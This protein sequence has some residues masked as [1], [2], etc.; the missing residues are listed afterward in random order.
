MLPSVRKFIN[1]SKEEQDI[2]KLFEDFINEVRGQPKILKVGATA[3]E[4]TNAIEDRTYIGIYYN[5]PNDKEVL[6]GFRLI[7]PYCYGKGYV[8]KRGGKKKVVYPNR[9]YIRAFVIR[10]S[11]YDSQFK[12][13]K[14]PF[15]RRKSASKTKK[16]PYWRLFRV[17]RIETWTTMKRKF[18]TYR[19][20]YNPQ[21]KQ[22]AKHIA[23]LSK[24]DFPEGSAPTK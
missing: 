23:Y 10:D 19:E 24:D 2:D 7:E 3:K 17:D 12:L 1:E 13:K 9:E 20:L 4:I 8:L 15:S 16:V 11:Q 18:F 14:T 21:D 6:P 5:D 22:I